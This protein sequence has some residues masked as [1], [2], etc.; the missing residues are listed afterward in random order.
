MGALNT[1]TREI[2]ELL[3]G[4]QVNPK[5]HNEPCCDRI[6]EFLKNNKDAKVCP[7]CGLGIHPDLRKAILNE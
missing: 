4:Q 3:E 5:P 2:V 7:Y 1:H 6:E